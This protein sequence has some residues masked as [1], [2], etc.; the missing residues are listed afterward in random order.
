VAISRHEDQLL[1]HVYGQ[2]QIDGQWVTVDGIVD[3]PFGWEVPQEEV[4]NRVEYPI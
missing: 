1:D 4:T 3:F 2:I